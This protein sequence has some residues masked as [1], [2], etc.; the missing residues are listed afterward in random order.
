MK[1]FLFEIIVYFFIPVLG[2][3][4]VSEYSLRQIPNDYS[5]KNRWMETNCKNLKVLCLGAS[6]IY[7]GI[8][9]SDMDINTFNGAHVSQTLNYDH[10]IF[11]KFINRMDSL[12]Y[13]VLGVDYWSP[14]SSLE[15]GPEWWRVRNYSI[16]YGCNYHKGELK[17]NYEL[18]FHNY[19]TFKR[20]AKGFLTSIGFRHDSN[21]N[22]NA[23]GFGLHYSSKNKKSNWDNG[24][25]NAL[26][27]NKEI[28]DVEYLNLIN[29]NR[30]YLQ[31]ICKKCADRNIKVFIVSAPEYKSYRAY[32]DKNYVNE[33]NGFCNS[34]AKSFKNVT[35]LD[36][37]SDKRFVSDDFFDAY[38]LNEIG[39]YKLT[40][41][42]NSKI[43]EMENAQPHSQMK[44][45]IDFRISKNERKTKMAC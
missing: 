28:K 32:S 20:A 17:Y 13:L 9:P 26:R 41:I 12:Q 27:N 19:Q 38:H 42:I 1:K 6:S 22:V 33:K 21:I 31:D 45:P 5:F 44:N 24:R 8:N 11:N 36:Y 25:E 23:L 7:Y 14:F 43:S 34:F 29:K 10:F 3:A 35:Y 37:S 15:E 4:I 18:Y 30:V 40:K 2:F 16:Y 39:A